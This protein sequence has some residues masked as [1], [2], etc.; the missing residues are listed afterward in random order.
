MV[1]SPIKKKS[2]DFA[3]RII[4]LYKYV[5]NSKNEYVL[6][7]QLLRSGT[8]IGANISEAE[9]AQSKADYI[10]KMSISLKETNET[11]YWLELLYKSD[12]LNEAEYTSIN[13][14]AVELLKM[15]TSIV[16]NSKTNI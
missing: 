2:V 16:K 6:S 3:L 8:S 13:E 7:K 12:Y 9:Y 5:T 1:E 14:N 10:A 4:K 11:V 15:L